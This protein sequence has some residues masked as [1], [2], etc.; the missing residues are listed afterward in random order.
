M[1][2]KPVGESNTTIRVDGQNQGTW[3]QSDDS[4][5]NIDTSVSRST[6]WVPLYHYNEY[7]RNSDSTAMAHI[8][9]SEKIHYAGFGS[10]EITVNWSSN[11]TMHD[12]YVEINGTKYYGDGTWTVNLSDGD[13]VSMDGSMSRNYSS[14]S[15]I[16]RC[17]MTIRANIE[18]GHSVNIN[19]V[20]RS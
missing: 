14:Q 3:T 12:P 11:G 8:N 6:S 7:E 2:F 9:R 10:N 15:P 19:S 4:T 16:L 18:T 20:N 13:V 17:E 5:Y 1:T